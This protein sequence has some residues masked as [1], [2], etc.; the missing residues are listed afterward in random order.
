[1]LCGCWPISPQE[2]RATIVVPG[3]HFSGRHPDPELDSTANW[4]RPSAQLPQL[5]ILDGQ[6]WHSTGPNHSDNLRIGIT[7]Y[8]CVPQ[9]RQQHF[10]L[11]TS[12]AVLESASEELLSLL[13]FKTWNGYGQTESPNREWQSHGQ[14]ALGEL[15]PTSGPSCV[16]YIEKTERDR[17]DRRP[18]FN[19][20]FSP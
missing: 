7:T 1:M 5:V 13:G 10:F 15:K 16:L 14:Y 9:F 3:S 2:N 6:I 11:G 12:P 19:A 18:I 8:F 20:L 17:Y 4:G